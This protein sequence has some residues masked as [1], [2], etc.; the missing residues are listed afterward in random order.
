MMSL[1]TVLKALQPEIAKLGSDLSNLRGPLEATLQQMQNIL[2]GM[3]VPQTQ[4]SSAASKLLYVAVLQEAIQKAMATPQFNVATAINDL[5]I[6]LD[7][8]PKAGVGLDANAGMQMLKLQRLMESKSKLVEALSNVMKAQH[9]TA[10]S[11]I[12]NMR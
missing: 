9:D 4:V 3:N 2:G 7:A 6:H 1:G 5:W 10:K 11:V 8:V 12:Q